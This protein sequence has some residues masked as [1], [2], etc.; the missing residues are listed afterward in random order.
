LSWWIAPLWALTTAR[1]PQGKSRWAHTGKRASGAPWV[2]S[3]KEICVDQGPLRESHDQ[4]PKP[5]RHAAARRGFGTLALGRPRR[6]RPH[7]P[8]GRSRAVCAICDLRCPVRSRCRRLVVA[9]ATTSPL[10]LPR[11]PW[12]QRSPAV[13]KSPGRGGARTFPVR[14]RTRPAPAARVPSLTHLTGPTSAHPQPTHP[15][16]GQRAAHAARRPCGPQAR[17]HRTARTTQPKDQPHAGKRSN[18]VH[19]PVIHRGRGAGSR[20]TNA[21]VIRA[22]F[23]SLEQLE[24]RPDHEKWVGWG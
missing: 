17:T 8:G 21:A 22:S 15:A 4:S 23:K 11:E 7:R 10:D 24:G 12:R 3:I 13:L 6:S 16:P 18:H 20:P 5:R 1:S 2:T 14:P 19:S 9:P